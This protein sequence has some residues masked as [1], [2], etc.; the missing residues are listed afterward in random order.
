MIV[1]NQWQHVAVSF[2]GL[3]VRLYYNGILQKQVVVTQTGAMAGAGQIGSYRNI[4]R[5]F[6][7]AIDE[8][9]LYDRPLSDAEMLGLYNL[10]VTFT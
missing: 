9:R 1:E 4:V 5:F 3:Y 2:D 10:S 8:V 7:G 6:S